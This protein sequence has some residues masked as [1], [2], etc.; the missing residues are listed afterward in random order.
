MIG[1]SESTEKTLNE[2]PI[3]REPLAPKCELILAQNQLLSL[4]VQMTK[5]RLK[6]LK[7]HRVIQSLKE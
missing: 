4:G 2:S 6:I 1:Q 3:K 7:F 5:K